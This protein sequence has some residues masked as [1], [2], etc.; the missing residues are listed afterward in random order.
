MRRLLVPVDAVA[1][2]VLMTVSSS[3]FPLVIAELRM[4]GSQ[5]TFI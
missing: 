2:D 3:G 1:S 5:M 4:P